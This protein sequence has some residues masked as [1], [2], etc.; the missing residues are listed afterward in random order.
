MKKD[1]PKIDIFV[2]GIYKAT[3]TWRKSCKDARKA[4]SLDMKIPKR[5]IIARLQKN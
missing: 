4:Y 3:T 5:H 1:Y 2:D